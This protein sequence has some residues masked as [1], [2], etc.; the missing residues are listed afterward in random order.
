MPIRGLADQIHTLNAT[1]TG[2]AD[3]DLIIRGASLANVYTGQLEKNIDIAIAG[4]RIAYVGQDAMHTAGPRTRIE[5]ANGKFVVPGMVDPHIHIDQFVTPYEFA[6]QAVLHGVTTLFSDPIDIVS[7]CG[8]RGFTEFLRQCKDTPAR[9]FNV[10]PGGLPVNRKWS[11]AKRLTRA[12]EKAALARNDVVGLGEVFSWTRVTERDPQTMSQLKYML[13]ANHVINGHTA[14]ASGKKLQAYVASGIFSCHEPIDYAQTLERLRIGMWVMIREGS[15]IRSLDEIITKILADKIDTSRLMFCSDG[16]SPPDMIDYGHI[17]HCVRQ[18]IKHGMNPVTAYTIASRNA[19]D[20]YSMSRDIGG[21]APGKLADIIVLDEL[22]SVRVCD[23]YVGGIRVVKNGRLVSRIKRPS[24]PAWISKTVRVGRAFNEND[25]AVSAS[26]QSVVNTITMKTPIITGMGS[27]TLEP[28]NGTLYADSNAGILKAANF[29]R[30]NSTHKGTVAFIEGL[31]RL[32]G[33]LATTWSFHED[34]LV[35]IGSNERDMAAAANIAASKGGGMA[36][37][38]N[39]KC[40]ADI[41]LDFAGILSS[42]MRFDK[43]AKSLR[44]LDSRVHDAGCKFTNAHLVPLFL[45]FLALPSV[46]LL[47]NGLVEIKSGKQIPIIAHSIQI[48]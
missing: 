3:A 47:H 44:G 25:F 2:N 27:V 31:G 21:I 9:I 45:P 40:V 10:V 17:D 4:E 26:T 14:G 37:V 15:I 42:S 7:V 12:Q 29:E 32:E 18:A 34:E 33:A 19:F 23:V 1:A 46:R 16:I 28:E 5:N 36:F 8:N 39:S 11:T 38:Q 22:Q 35:V 43:V 41:R 24:L 6:S 13:E 48:D 30:A 20:Y